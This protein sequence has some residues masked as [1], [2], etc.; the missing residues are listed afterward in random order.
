MAPIG[1]A[2]DRNSGKE[3]LQPTERDTRKRA[4]D[5]WDKSP[6]R[7][8]VRLSDDPVRRR[9]QKAAPPVKPPAPTAV[10]KNPNKSRKRNSDDISFDEGSS[11]TSQSSST[12]TDS[13][14][15]LR[16]RKRAKKSIASLPTPPGLTQEEENDLL[17][18]S[19]FLIP[20]TTSYQPN[21]AKKR[22][23]DPV[24]AEDIERCEMYEES[25]LSAQESSVSQL[26]NHLLATFS[27]TPTGK[28]R[29]ALRKEFLLMYSAQPFPLTYGRVHASLLYGALSITQ[30]VLSGSS[31]ARTF[32]VPPKNSFPVASGWGTDV[33]AREKFLEIFMKSY[34]QSVL[35]TALEVVVGREMFAYAMPGESEKKVL[36]T[37]MDRYLINSEDILSTHFE[38][39]QVPKKGVK[40]GGNAKG[41]EDIGTPAWMLRRTIL[42]SF[43][44]ILLLDKAKSR[45]AL[46]RQCLFKKESTLKSSLE[47]LRAVSK[48]LIPSHGDISK[49][50]SHLNYTLEAVQDPLSEF[51]YKIDNIA[52]DM[53]DGIRLTRVAEVLLRSKG[54]QSLSGEQDDEEDDWPL[55]LHLQH[56]AT[57]RVQKMHNVNLA[58]SALDNA[59][60]KPHRIEAKDIVDGY[61]EKTVGLLWGL[62]SQWGLELLLDWNTVI[63]ETARLET[64]ES[65]DRANDVVSDSR[66]YVGLLKNWATCIA[67]K[68]GLVVTNLTTSFADGKVFTA[69]VSEYERYLPSYAK[70]GPAASLQ[71]KLRGI[72]CNSYFGDYPKLEVIYRLC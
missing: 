1:G 65:S 9:A 64:K 29:L 19:E 56:P 62:L 51:D 49:P 68:H 17:P 58:L 60:G 44:L 67:A 21:P 54:R 14:G 27:P 34:D 22:P 53:R 4:A 30:Y 50:M 42:R 41:D 6:T 8:S 15:T 23:L 20:G 37:Y 18:P 32:R 5:K 31:V 47:V 36:E 40:L 24:L 63:N 69:I 3:N 59:G 70:S 12:Y 28:K 38:P 11:F 33:G 25:W 46:G 57:S 52:V 35:I 13:F 10:P 61:R 2:R 71:I 55:S 39:I 48:L 45:G 7:K 66:D 16:L 43:M 26:L 72:G